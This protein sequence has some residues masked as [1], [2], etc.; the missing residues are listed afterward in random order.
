VRL[1]DDLRKLDLD[2]IADEA[3]KKAYLKRMEDGRLTRDENPYSHFCVFFLPYNPKTKRLFLVHHKKADTWI[4]PGGHID[5]GESYYDTIIRE[6]RE[7]LHANT[8]KNNFSKPFLATI[9][10][11]SNPNQICQIHHDTWFLFK[12]DGKD[13]RPDM[14]EFHDVAWLTLDEARQR[15]VDETNIKALDYI[16]SNFF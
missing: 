10:K 8:N 9:K 5:Q 15:V 3:T 11:I 12:T 7:E 6:I 13:F 16:E 4:S 14:T 2:T 1:L